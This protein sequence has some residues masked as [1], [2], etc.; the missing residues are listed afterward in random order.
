MDAGFDPAYSYR[1]PHQDYLGHAFT[2]TLLYLDHRRAGM[3]IPIIPFAVNAYGADLIK[4]KGGLAAKTS[5]A[6]GH[7]QLPALPAPT[8]ARCFDLGRTIA[9]TLMASSWRVALVAT[10]DLSHSF[11]TAKNDFLYPDTASDRA[12]L[13][14]LGAADYMAWRNLGLDTLGDAGQHELVNWCPM[15]GAMHELGQKPSYCELIESELMATN[16]SVAIIPPNA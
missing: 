10:G 15:V 14:E 4:S 1:L 5:V 12:R 6:G 16:K 13:A 7:G 8:P 2:N 11:L 9:R 3:D